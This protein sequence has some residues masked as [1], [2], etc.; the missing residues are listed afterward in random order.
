MQDPEIRHL[1]PQ[2]TATIHGETTATGLPALLAELLPEVFETVARAGLEPAGMPFV[3]YLATPEEDRVVVEA[4]VPL[5]APFTGAGRVR[6]HELP[7]GEVAVAQHF[8][9]Y[10]TIA[11]TYDALGAWLAERGREG[12]DTIWEAYWTDPETEPDPACWRTELFWPLR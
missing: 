2:P 8:G 10:E 3:H 6:P 5:A 4:G 9:P 12:G 1:A 11:E 7:G